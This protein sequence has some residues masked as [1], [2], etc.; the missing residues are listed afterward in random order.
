[1]PE[2]VHVVEQADL[3]K[4]DRDEIIALMVESFNLE[5][6]TA[7]IQFSN[8][9]DLCP[10]K[11]FLI[12][13]NKCGMILGVF[14]VVK[15][16]IFLY[17]DIEINVCGISYGFVRNGYRNYS[18]SFKLTKALFD[19]SSSNSFDCILGFSRKALDEYWYPFGFLGFTNFGFLS[20]DYEHITSKLNEMIVEDYSQD[21]L[22]DI[23]KI[24]QDYQI[25]SAPYFKRDEKDWSY[26]LKKIELNDKKIRV[27][28]K[29]NGEF[30]GYFIHS[31]NRVI[32][33]AVRSGYYSQ[34]LV[35]LRNY[36]KI[37][38]E[39]EKKIFFDIGLQSSF[40]RFIKKNLAHSINT[41]F[42][43]RGGHIIRIDELL[44]FFKKITPALERR[45]L[46][47]Y[48]LNFEFIL[49]G[50]QFSYDQK[51]LLISR[52]DNENTDSRKRRI[53]WQKM[54]FGI[55]MPGDILDNELECNIE[56]L[57][58]ILFPLIQ[59][60]VLEMDQF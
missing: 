4:S 47:V 55:Q 19:Y 1:M 58:S 40:L 2:I 43:W 16:K 57:C 32:E 31:N 6:K 27:I 46:K 48:P 42:Y 13:K 52:V 7:K 41:R 34:S 35:A 60:Q 44:N 23:Q 15:R 39:N 25:F 21:H 45:L 37:Y 26:I 29:L 3:L 56:L 24:Y 59:P 22:E 50:Y 5:E 28:S 12:Y 17:D 53:F 30:S 36:F 33:L 49:E 20:I 8:F 51:R 11:A 54:I 14:C 9:I 10:D 38:F 18:V